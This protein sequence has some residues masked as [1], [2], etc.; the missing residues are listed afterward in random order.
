VKRRNL[1]S[2]ALAL[3]TAVALS[4]AFAA[5]FSYYPVSIAISPVLPP[6]YFA[7]GKNAGQNDL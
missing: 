7:S 3:L 4:I 6:V 2:L 1:L 5:V